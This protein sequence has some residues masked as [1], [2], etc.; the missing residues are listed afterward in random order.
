MQLAK[1]AHLIKHLQTHSITQNFHYISFAST[2]L[3]LLAFYE[4]PQGL[5][6]T[7]TFSHLPQLAKHTDFIKCLQAHR[8]D[9]LHLHYNNLS[10][11]NSQEFV[12]C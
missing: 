11:G 7:M 6:A 5:A 9:Y 12:E 4:N 8:Q 3:K 2:S 1:R 10:T